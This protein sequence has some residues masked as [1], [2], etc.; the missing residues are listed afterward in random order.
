V[1]PSLEHSRRVAE[2]RSGGRVLLEAGPGKRSGI[3]NLYPSRLDIGQTP[4][5]G[6]SIAHLFV[7][8]AGFCGIL[9]R[10]SVSHVT[11]MM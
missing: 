3:S 2:D 11:Y 7:S 9:Y 5:K 1:P 4:P 6:A 8:V 10:E